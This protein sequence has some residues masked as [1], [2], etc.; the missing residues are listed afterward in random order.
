MPA[1]LVALARN[2]LAAKL[3]GVAALDTELCA[4]ELAE[5]VGDIYKFVAYG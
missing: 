3:L 5:L 1:V 4:V 2:S